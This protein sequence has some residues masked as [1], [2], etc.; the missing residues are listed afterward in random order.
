MK[1]TSAWLSLFLGLSPKC[2]QAQPL[3][4][5]V[6]T[7]W[8]HPTPK[9]SRS[10]IYLWHGG[11]RPGLSAIQWGGIKR[12]LEVGLQWMTREWQGQIGARLRH[13]E[14]QWGM[15]GLMASYAVGAPPR[16]SPYIGWRNDDLGNKEAL[17][18]RGWLTP[19]GPCVLIAFDS[20]PRF[21]GWQGCV[22]WVPVLGPEGWVGWESSG[23]S[24]CKMFLSTKKTLLFQYQRQ[25]WIVGISWHGMAIPYTWC[26]YSRPWD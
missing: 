1:I 17:E 5:G 14:N 16:V 11:S 8:I 4:I 24:R 12:H 9:A 26:G 13:R 10:E 23:E 2:L 6:H 25:W 19:V 21:A 15:A 22:K 7:P 3:A 18:V 20:G